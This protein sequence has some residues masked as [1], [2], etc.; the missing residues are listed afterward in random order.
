M[1]AR[2]PYGF[3]DLKQGSIWEHFA[4]T[5]VHE[6]ESTGR[7]ELTETVEVPWGGRH[8][9]VVQLTNMETG[10]VATVFSRALREGPRRQPHPYWELTE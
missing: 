2:T 8:D 9:P 1:A 6:G 7:Y 3:T 5:V 4:S 10:G